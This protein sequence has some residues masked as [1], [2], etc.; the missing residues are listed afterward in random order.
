MNNFYNDNKFKFYLP[1]WIFIVFA[2]PEA[3][4]D[5]R[6]AY[7]QLL[8]SFVEDHIRRADEKLLRLQRELKQYQTTK[9]K[10][11][12]DRIVREIETEIS[13]LNGTQQQLINEL[14]RTDLDHIERYLYEKSKDE[15][16][17]L[18]KHYTQMLASIKTSVV[19]VRSAEVCKFENI[20]LGIFCTNWTKINK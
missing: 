16:E 11:L 3:P 17:L 8:F 13:L 18:T 9:D 6:Q 14:K 10:E 15:A 5:W 12:H 1:F 20:L 2:P 4:T 19:V 7:D